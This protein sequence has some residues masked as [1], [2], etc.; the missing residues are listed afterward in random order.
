[1]PVAGPSIKVIVSH[2]GKQHSYHLAKALLDIGALDS[3]HT[4]SYVTWP[5]L[6]KLVTATG[7]TFFSRRFKPGLAAPY[8]HAHWGQELAEMLE[9]F[10][11]GRG[12][13]F[14]EAVYRR[15]EI[16]DNRMAKQL[17]GLPGQM[18][19]GFQGS[20]LESLKAA[21]QSGKFAI[22]ELATA[23]V[24]AAKKIL[25]EEA[26]LYPDWADSI[27]NLTFAPHYEARLEAEPFE[28]DLVIA[29][30]RFT[31]ATL[32]DAG[33]PSSKISYLPLGFDLEHVPYKERMEGRGGRPFRFLYAGNVTQRKGMSYLL[34]AME[35]LQGPNS[36]TPIELHIVGTIT[37]SG[38][39][40][41]KRESLYIY[42]PP[43]SQAELFA[44]YGDYDALVL[45]TLFEGFGLVL[46]E[47]MAAGLPII[48]TGHSIGPD[49]IEQDVNGAL[50]PIRDSEALAQAMA[51][52]ADLPE[53][54][55]L[56]MRRAA[57]ATALSYT[58]EA[59]A[60]RLKMFLDTLSAKL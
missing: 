45:P 32:L 44:M 14:A 3:F 13:G 59:Y 24:T 4:G 6:Q 28:A 40:F 48:T 46:V 15:D 1:M 7:N 16:H 55:Y 42:H 12:A 5:I 50:V 47:A 53:A 29:A 2:A 58:W 60:G 39:A 31:Q 41:R 30:S 11:H 56:Q 43:V 38:E 35:R 27:D 10:R 36:Y 51:R 54:Y 8:V 37:G 49:L 22:L 20:T 19:W 21:R 25:G 17:P 18:F 34:D 9:K 23:H 26:L 52:M 57:R 33:V